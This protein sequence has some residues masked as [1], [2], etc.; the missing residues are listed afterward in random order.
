M[1]VVYVIL[2]DKNL[3]WNVAL[4]KEMLDRRF[5]Q[6]P[7]D[8]SMYN[9]DNILLKLNGRQLCQLL[10]SKDKDEGTVKTKQSWSTRRSSLGENTLRSIIL[11]ASFDRRD[12]EKSLLAVPCKLVLFFS[13]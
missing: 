5:Q 7:G 6:S 2:L 11:Q 10:L 3:N 4:L 1:C 12:D 13:H 8:K 9:L